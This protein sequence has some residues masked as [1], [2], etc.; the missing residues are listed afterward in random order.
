MTLL[1]KLFSKGGTD[2]IEKTTTQ[3]IGE[4]KLILEDL[5]ENEINFVT[6][7]IGLAT[8][9]FKDLGIKK[10]NH[11]FDPSNIKRGIETWFSF[12]LQ[13]KY[14]LDQ[15][16]YSD[17]LACGWGNY[18][19]EML[20]MEWHEITDNYGTEIGVYHKNNNVTIFPFNSMSKA[21]GEK[22]FELI[23]II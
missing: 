23:S 18:L 6:N 16:M 5:N 11:I 21:F 15:N 8:E 9:L 7:N 3:P 4:S 17:A 19:S 22:N 14:Q 12:D 1:K 20:G 2:Y 10:N 13:T